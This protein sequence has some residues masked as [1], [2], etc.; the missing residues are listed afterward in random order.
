MPNTIYRA[1]SRGHANHGWLDS[2]HSFSFAGYYNPERVHFGALRV[3]ND[4]IVKGGMGFGT[5]PHHD[6]EIVSI[7]LK[8]ALEH[9]DDTGRHGVIKTGD[10]QIMS[11]GSG[12][13]HSE[14]NASKTDEVN[15]LQVWVFPKKK[16]ITPRYDQKAFDTKDRENKFQTVVSPEENGNTLWINQDA[17]F[18]LGKL[19]QGAEVTYPLKKKGDGVYAFVISGEATIDGNPLEQRDAVLISDKEGINVKATEDSEV[20][21]IEIPMSF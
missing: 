1:S 8:G 20:L 18:S 21:I 10:V 9:R 15:F 3:F 7:P 11:A 14:F 17:W 2:H 6:M 16:N 12:I 4:D 19:K 5:H 13:A